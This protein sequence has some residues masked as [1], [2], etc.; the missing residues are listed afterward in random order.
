MASLPPLVGPKVVHL[1]TD[2]SQGLFSPKKKSEKLSW[3]HEIILDVLICLS[4]YGS[5][6]WK[7]FWSAELKDFCKDKRIL[8]DARIAT[9]KVAATGAKQVRDYID[10]PDRLVVPTF[11]ITRSADEPRKP[12]S[13]R[14]EL[15][16]SPKESTTRRLEASPV[17]L[18]FTV[19][20][21]DLTDVSK[22]QE[23]EILAIG[24]EAYDACLAS[25][26]K[27]ESF[28]VVEAAASAAKEKAMKD[29]R[30]MMGLSGVTQP[31]QAR[32]NVFADECRRCERAILNILQKYPD[33]KESEMRQVLRKTFHQFNDDLINRLIRGLKYGPDCEG[34]KISEEMPLWKNERQ[35]RELFDAIIDSQ[36]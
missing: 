14:R 15:M 24:D 7:K 28:V 30:D 22:N 27:D 20:D 17:H 13:P 10:V 36:P 2:Y 16:R 12:F 35:V 29:A 8:Q 5:A 26:D 11:H 21:Q 1:E 33:L 9:K 34:F 3:Y 32:R 4:N 23:E 6:G 19:I 31:K 25:G 18:I